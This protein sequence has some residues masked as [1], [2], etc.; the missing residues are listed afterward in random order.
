M[1][2]LLWQAPPAPVACARFATHSQ[3]ARLDDSLPHCRLDSSDLLAPIARAARLRRTSRY[4]IRLLASPAR[5]PVVPIRSSA[6]FTLS[7]GERRA[8]P[9]LH[10][11]A[12]RLHN[13]RALLASPAQHPAQVLRPVAVLSPCFLTNIFT[14][15][16]SLRRRTLQSCERRWR[17]LALPVQHGRT[18]SQRQPARV[19]L[20]QVSHS[21]VVV[22]LCCVS[23]LVY[24]VLTSLSWSAGA[25]LPRL[26]ASHVPRVRCGLA[27]AEICC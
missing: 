8:T 2:L 12:H 9:S 15:A 18:I 5:C 20:R 23:W 4:R 26:M 22:M 3:L 24:A 11:V 1:R 21:A 17:V 7:V 13:A 19:P 6:L 25:L 10:W 27:C 14:D 16:C